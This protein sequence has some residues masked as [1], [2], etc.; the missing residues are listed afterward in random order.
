MRKKLN[1]ID[2]LTLALGSIIGWGSFT[3]PGSKFLHESGIISTAIGLILGGFAIVFI[4]KGYHIMMERHHEDGGE[5]SYTYKSLGKANGF[6]VGWSLT[7]CYISMVPLNATAFVLVLKK[8]FGPRVDFIYLYKVAGYP[9]YF[10]EIIIS[11]LI[12]LL[13][14]YVNTKGLSF[15]S[16]I[17]NILILLMVVNVIIV[18]VFMLMKTDHS[19]IMDTYI[20]NYKLNIAEVVK[21]FAIVPFLFVGFDV[22]PQVSTELNFEAP[23]ATRIAIVAIF[24]GVFF[25]NLLN[26]TTGLIYSPE[27]ALLEQ[28][29]LGSAVL[30]NIGYIGFI[31]LIISLT[32]AVAG[33]ING[34]M[35]GSSKLIGSLS[36]YG[37]I[38]IKY[39][40]ENHNGVFEN[41]VKFVA[42]ISLIAPWFGREA[43]IYIVDMSSLLSAIAYFYV[44][45]IGFKNSKGSNRYL[46]AMG[47]FIS[48][49]FIGLLTIPGSP[50]RL[51]S[52]SMVLMLLWGVL[53]YLYY[54]RYS[55]TMK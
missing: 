25:Y 43:I 8:L 52:P 28:W 33:G 12:I 47:A 5:F 31:L 37:L 36:V 24:A 35:L 1:K 4:Q 50:G 54:R 55:N 42:L 21:V 29:A 51:S 3:L 48:L 2:I 11:S 20:I 40:K 7:L 17:Q 46:S 32:G 27:K 9:V 6:I 38:P 18:F 16:M 45:Y 34:F 44:C 10:S 15:S 22:I 30:D 26:I 19:L 39:K 13:F 41:G 14:A 23:K 53:G 49:V